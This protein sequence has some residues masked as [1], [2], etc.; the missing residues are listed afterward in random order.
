MSDFGDF[1]DDDATDTAPADPEQVARKL[2]RIRAEVRPG[3]PPPGRSSIDGGRAVRV[4]VITRLLLWL[5]RQGA[6]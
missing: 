5:R 3:D 6:S 4:A 2:Q 1:D